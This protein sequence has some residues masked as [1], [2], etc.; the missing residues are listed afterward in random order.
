MVRGPQC[1]GCTP[2]PLIGNQTSEHQLA[3]V[4]LKTN[5]SYIMTEPAPLP[6]LLNLHQNPLKTE[7]ITISQMSKWRL[8]EVTWYSQGH[9]G[10]WK[11]QSRVLP[12][13]PLSPCHLRTPS[14][15]QP[16][17]AWPPYLCQ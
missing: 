1:S 7:L 15:P 5:S 4:T 13:C 6:C 8:R 2:H 9:K 3:D 10:W 12:K 11:G 16:H 17:L 14:L